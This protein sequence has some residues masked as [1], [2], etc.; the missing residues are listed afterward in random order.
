MPDKAC[1]LCVALLLLESGGTARHRSQSAGPLC[2]SNLVWGF[3]ALPPT[4]LWGLVGRVNREREWGCRN[5]IKVGPGSGMVGS[6]GSVSC[7]TP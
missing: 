2:C 6:L 4:C 3:G 5:D 7:S 1:W